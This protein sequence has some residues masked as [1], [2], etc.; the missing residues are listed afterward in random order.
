MTEEIFA[1]NRAYSTRGTHM[2]LLSDAMEA[3]K[4]KVT[5]Q[6]KLR[7]STVLDDEDVLKDQVVDVDH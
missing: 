5:K 4:S 6:R 1:I 2:K 3:S 7:S